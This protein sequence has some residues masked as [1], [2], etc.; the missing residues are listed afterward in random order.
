MKLFAAVRTATEL[1]ASGLIEMNM[2]EESAADIAKVASRHQDGYQIARALEDRCG[3]DCDLPIA[4][5]LDGFGGLLDEE[6]RKACVSWVKDNDV[7]PPFPVGTRVSARWGGDIIT[8]TIGE[9]YAYGPAQY[10]IKRDGEKA[11]S[12]AI[13]NF[14]DVSELAHA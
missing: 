7:Q 9:I 10:C 2:V 11:S 13:A 5:G 12:R 4:E 3:W 8:G 1:A 6:I 14:E